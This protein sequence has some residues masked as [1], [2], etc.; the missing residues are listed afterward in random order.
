MTTEE[1]LNVL[2]DNLVIAIHDR[3]GINPE[4]ERNQVESLKAAIFALEKQIPCNTVLE[5]KEGYDIPVCSA[6]GG[7]IYL[8]RGE[9]KYCPN[10]GQALD[11]SGT[12]K[13]KTVKE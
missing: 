3:D 13:N 12:D 7:D 2:Q 9:A 4:Y 11:W 6:C 5:T 8:M 10:C 1:A